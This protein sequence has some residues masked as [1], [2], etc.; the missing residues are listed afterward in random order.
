[1]S[2]KMI[3]RGLLAA[4]ILAFSGTLRASTIPMA[5]VPVGNAGNAADTNTGSL[6]RICRLQLQHWH[7]RRDAH[8]VHGLS[9]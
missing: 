5:T 9:R 1:M 3:V 8:A 7:R 4:A 6:V 2:N